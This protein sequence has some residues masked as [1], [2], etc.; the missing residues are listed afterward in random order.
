[1]SCFSVTSSTADALE[2]LKNLTSLDK[3]SVFFESEGSNECKQHEEMLLSSLGKLGTCRLS[4]WTHKWRGSLEFLD[5]WTPLP[6]SLENFRMSGGCYFM[7]IPKWI[8]T[9]PRNLAYLEISLTESREEDLHTL[10]KLP[11]LLYLK[12]SFIADPIERITVQGTSGFLS[13]KEFVIYSVA[14]AYVNFMEGAMPS[15]EKLNV[16]LHVSLAKNYGFNLGIQHLPYLK[17]AVVSLYKVDVT[18]SEINAAAAAIR[19]EARDHSNRP[20]IDISG[21]SYEKHNEEIG[22]YVAEIKEV[23]ETSGSS[24][25]SG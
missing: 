19:N 23:G 15:L 12:L 5:S 1:M 24:S 14:G 8:S 20:T 17:E 25:F 16:R 22:S 2:E 9:L 11:A 21:E 6:S 3:L 7:N 18:P 4:L 13:L 10:G